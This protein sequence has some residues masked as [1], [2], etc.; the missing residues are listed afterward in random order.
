MTLNEYLTRDNLSAADLARDLGCGRA[1]V[2]H[3][4]NGTKPLGRGTAVK[5]W[6]KRKV[7][8]DPIA[9]LSDADLKVLARLDEAA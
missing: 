6:A 9:H 7:K 2:T 1:Y 3:L 4:K 5:I 8:L